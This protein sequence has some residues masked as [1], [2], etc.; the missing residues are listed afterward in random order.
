VSRA[1]FN[2]TKKPSV[3]KAGDTIEAAA[4]IALSGWQVLEALPNPAIV[5]RPNSALEYANPGFCAAF[6]ASFSDLQA[7]ATLQFDGSGSVR[8]TR[9]ADE[10]TMRVKHL[11]GDLLMALGEA[12]YEDDGILPPYRLDT[13]TGL[14]DRSILDPLFKQLSSS[15]ES[16]SCALLMIDLDRFK[17]VNDT[18]GHPVGDALLVKVVERLK[19]TVREQDTLLRLGGDEFALVQCG[20]RQPEAAETLAQRLIDLVSRTYL[21]EDHVV[22]IGVSIGVSVQKSAAAEATSLLTS[23]D[24]ALYRAKENGRGQYYFFEPALARAAFKKRELETELRR[25]I[26]LRQFEVH[27]QPLADL[28]D[29][30]ITGIEAL[31]RWRHPQRG[32]LLPEEF[33]PVAE[34]TGFITQIGDFVLN[35]ACMAAVNW[36]NEQ[37]LAVNLSPVQIENET[38]VDSVKAALARSGLPPH[39][40]EIEVTE[41]LMIGDMAK[42]LDVLN[43]LKALGVRIVMDDFGTGYS[44]LRYL[45]AFPFDKVKIDRSFIARLNKDRNTNSIIR[46]I[47][48]LGFTLGMKTTAEGVETQEQLEALKLEGCNEVQGYLISRPLDEDGISALLNDPDDFSGSTQNAAADETAQTQ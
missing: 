6:D 23:A 47:V 11:P 39:R 32:L 2:V 10:I 19:S 27:Y 20:A 37:V 17:N 14:P 38:V 12:A 45:Q 31:V 46:T 16:G 22:N 15:K 43:Q 1:H 28:A 35:K 25:A 21:I 36:P 42:A 44:S 4:P 48:D 9:G 29:N 5:F 40:L 33:L 13:L 26:A 7:S 18:L 8:V 3:P 34:D 24:L 41:N 30:K